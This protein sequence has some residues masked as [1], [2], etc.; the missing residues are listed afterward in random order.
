MSLASSEDRHAPAKAFL[1][2]LVCTLIFFFPSLTHHSSSAG[3][4]YTGDVLGFYWPST[5]KMQQLIS[6]LH[7][8]AIDI[9]VFNGASDFYP[10]PN[11][12]GVQPFLVI[13]SL[14]SGP[15]KPTQEDVGHALVTAMALQ[16]FLSCYFTVRIGQRFMDLPLGAAAV[17]A[18]VFN[19]G[20]GML[21]GLGEP[22]YLFAVGP[23]PWV[24]YSALAF[25]R[26]PSLLAL[27]WA[28]FPTVGLL[29]GGYMPLGVASLFLA[30]AVIVFLVMT[31]E[32]A[33]PVSEKVFRLVVAFTPMA[34]AVVVAAPYMIEV[35]RFMKASPSAHFV[36]LL[37]SAH[38]LA[39]APQDILRLFSL[40][41]RVPGPF[42]EM[43]VYLGPV[44]AY[45]ALLF[46]VSP[47]A[48]RALSPREWNRLVWMFAGYALTCLSIYGIYSAVSDMVFHFVP[49]VGGMHIYQR[50][51]YPGGLLSGLALA[52]M[53]T[54]LVRAEAAV[55]YR[56]GA[57][58]C[59]L[60]AFYVAYKVAFHPEAWD[61]LGI[62]NSL[63]IELIILA[64]FACALIIPQ[65]GAKMAFAVCLVA[66]PLLNNMYGYSRTGHDLSD[67]G[68]KQQILLDPQTQSAI[69]DYMR[70]HQPHK[71]LIKYADVTPLWAGGVEPFSKS[72]P[73]L[74]QNRVALSSYSG[75]NTYL[76]PP[77]DYM[78]MMPIAPSLDMQPEWRYVRRTGGDFVV[79]PEAKLPAL[80]SSGLIADTQT[81]VMHLPGAVAVAPLI[82]DG[83]LDE[84]VYDN[85]YFRV[86]Y[87]GAPEKPMT[88]LALHK[89][90]QES[91]QIGDSSAAKAVDG[92]LNG[93][94]SK[95]S[96]SH[97]AA[98]VNAWLQVDL[99]QPQ[100]IDAIQLFNRTDCCG[101]RLS[102][103]WVMASN[104]PFADGE[105]ADQ[106]RARPGVW[107]AYVPSLGARLKIR[108]R[109]VTGRYVRV[110]FDGQAIR[111]DRY[112]ALAELQVL[113]GA[114]DLAPAPKP[115]APTVTR[116]ST[117][118]A[119]IFEID[120]NAP[121]GARVTYALWPHSGL[122]FTVDGK[123]VQPL[124]E[125]G[126]AVMPVGPGRHKIA[127]R[128][129]STV[130]TLF[131]VV[132]L[133]FLAACA[134][135]SAWWA[136]RRLRRREPAADAV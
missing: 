98:D 100:R 24:I 66:L 53:L 22:E 55:L 68:P 65:P 110:Q 33:R 95:G 122:R 120:V 9:G 46:L 79:A 124:R 13:Y 136:Y 134:G 18:V 74:V 34:C 28:M 126:A 109:A 123:R 130:H 116:F 25:E 72:F 78:A 102:H 14:F 82:P 107:S 11:Y 40:N 12:F 99:G 88:N 8:S 69:A 35:L 21:S 70:A 85:G 7:F 36:S 84:P 10:T 39:E 19:F 92:D 56:I 62:N 115:A 31:D 90:A 17:A 45:I 101:D 131:W 48:G 59:L 23:L 114:A 132:Y 129:H 64:L 16:V 76:T 121:G 105:T 81:G 2:S 73:Y 113:Q 26:R 87:P 104:E 42:A 71:D 119:N 32:E 37:Y 112:L 49:Q 103:F 135:V 29:L 1:F 80:A 127:V 44:G 117:N 77:G 67:L 20:P 51:L 4:L 54:A 6:H 86:D 5:I 96:V 47:S 128:Y 97:T 43:S 108:T 111:N 91:S 75:F 57:A 93:D 15:L 27:P 30:V 83:Q 3:Y 94:F 52:L 41:W 106:A 63:V 50:F 38:D 61:K 60:L 125:D 133:S 118:K 58:V 89:P